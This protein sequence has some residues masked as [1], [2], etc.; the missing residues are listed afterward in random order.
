MKL[1]ASQVADTINPGSQTSDAMYPNR[2]YAKP[3][4]KHVFE[5]SG[6]PGLV[7]RNPGYVLT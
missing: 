5:E 4:L 3:I 7:K 1:A 2:V 6:I